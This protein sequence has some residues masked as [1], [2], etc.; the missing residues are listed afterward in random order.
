MP[1]PRASISVTD[2]RSTL[3][4]APASRSRHEVQSA[5][6]WRASTR[7]PDTRSDTWLAWRLQSAVN[8]LEYVVPGAVIMMNLSAG[9]RTRANTQPS[10]PLTRHPVVDP[11]VDGKCLLSRTG[12]G[13]LL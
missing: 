11:A 10:Y 13:R 12:R 2:P 8:G 7:R 1:S 4:F 6:F 9:C 5:V 3:T